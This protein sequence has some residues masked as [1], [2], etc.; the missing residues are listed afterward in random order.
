LYRDSLAMIVAVDV[1]PEIAKLRKWTSK[2]FVLLRQR[3]RG[4]RPLV[5]RPGAQVSGTFYEKQ[6]RTTST[7]LRRACSAVWSGFKG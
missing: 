1:R 2:V 5:P 7:S 4:S 3:T 6:D